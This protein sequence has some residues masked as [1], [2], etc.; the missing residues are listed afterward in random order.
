MA[1]ASKTWNRV[2]RWLRTLHIFLSLVGSLV[3]LLFAVSG[4]LLN[5]S[6]WFGFAKGAAREEREGEVPRELLRDPDL[7]RLHAYLAEHHGLPRRATLVEIEGY[8]VRIL[9][10]YPGSRIDAFIDREEGF[11][12]V[13][14]EHGNLAATLGA[15]HQ[16]EGTGTL[17][18]LLIDAASILLLLSALSGLWLW[19]TL[20]ARRALGWTA[21]ASGALI[22]AIPLV[23]AFG[24]L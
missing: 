12:S 17:G 24:I 21:L 10:E 20:P 13:T 19:W 3:L 6:D 11:L 4:F 14:E 2:K 7:P 1:P 8:E 22:L 23:F 16:G 18:I 9:Y 5:H 15:I